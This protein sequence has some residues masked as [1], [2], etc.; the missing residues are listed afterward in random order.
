MNFLYF[1]RGFY[2]D[3]REAFKLTYDELVKKGKSNSWDKYELYYEVDK[4]KEKP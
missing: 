4:D 3:F 1:L 2:R